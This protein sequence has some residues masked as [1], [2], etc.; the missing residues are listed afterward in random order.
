MLEVKPIEARIGRATMVSMV[1]FRRVER[2]KYGLRKY[3]L[4]ISGKCLEK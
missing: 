3:A 4:I 1:L 2:V